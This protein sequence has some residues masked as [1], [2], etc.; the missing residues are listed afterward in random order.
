MFVSLKA[1]ICEERQNYIMTDNHSIKE[2]IFPK[3]YD[4]FI[5]KNNSSEKSMHF[6]AA[7]NSKN[8]FISYFDDIFGNN[9]IEKLYILGGGPGSGKS[10]MMKRIAK[11]SEKY[12]YTT[13][14]IHCSSSPFSLDGVIIREKKTAVIDGTA[15]HTYFPSAAGVREI[16]VDLG[17]A[18]DTE[19]LYSRKDEIYRLN[20][21]KKKQYKKAYIYLRAANL[22][23]CE[24]RE[25]V[26][27]CI[28]EEKLNK[29]A[30]VCAADA[31]P[32]KKKTSYDENGSTF[33]KS[34]RI[35]RAV[36]AAGNIYFDTFS[37][38][39][40][41][42]FFVSDF[43]GTA[44]MWFDALYKEA[45]TRCADITVSYSPE[46]PD[47]IDGIYFNK[48]KTAFTM[49]ASEYD[50]IINCE[51]FVDKGIISSIRQKYAFATKSRDALL[52]EAYD[53][54]E[55]AGEYHNDIEAQYYPCTDYSITEEITQNLCNEI[56]R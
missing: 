27:H 36:S 17:K 41:K 38:M 8:G 30:A 49:Y 42:T 40:D 47:I 1:Y 43:K 35:Q 16:C 26:K 44:A 19:A 37:R 23:D 14:H 9:D 18:W 48:S 31:I 25:A 28:L 50:K 34:I 46:N 33:K 21:A 24:A 4:A 32:K 2:I 53:A 10:T 11:T 54:L 22:I 56:F 45:K 13:E 29:N 3:S 7:A 12:G 15:P 52:A 55:S 6:F 39:A 51:R 5:E 20:N